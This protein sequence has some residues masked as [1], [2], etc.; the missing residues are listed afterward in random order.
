MSKRDEN[1]NSVVIVQN[2]GTGNTITTESA[3]SSTTHTVVQTG[4]G[5]RIIHGGNPGGISQTF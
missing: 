1:K 3:S 4:E 5:S 2:G